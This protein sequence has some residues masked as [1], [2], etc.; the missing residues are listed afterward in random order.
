M[1]M[2]RKLPQAWKVYNILIWLQFITVHYKITCNILTLRMSWFNFNKQS[3]YCWRSK[4]NLFW[5]IS[6]QKLF[7]WIIVINHVLWNAKTERT[8]PVPAYIF[9]HWSNIACLPASRINT[10]R[11]PV[12]ANHLISNSENWSVLSLIV[13]MLAPA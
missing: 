4:I 12:E 2:N 13:L 10:Q 8:C 6:V 9:A 11:H 1:N 3:I 7:Q 5:L